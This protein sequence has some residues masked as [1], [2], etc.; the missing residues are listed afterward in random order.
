MHVQPGDAVIE[1][2]VKDGKAHFRMK[3]PEGKVAFETTAFESKTDCVNGIFALH[4]YASKTAI[5]DNA[6]E[7][8]H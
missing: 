4:K 7:L 1:I 3:T 2:F 6:K 8:T 5:V